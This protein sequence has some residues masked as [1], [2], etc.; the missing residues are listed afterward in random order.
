MK[1]MHKTAPFALV[2]LLILLSI[3]CSG[4]GGEALTATPEATATPEPT[5]TPSTPGVPAGWELVESKKGNIA[6][7]FPPGWTEFDLDPDT[8][9][10]ALD[11]VTSENPELADLLTGQ[12]STLLESGAVLFG[13]DLRSGAASKFSA[14]MNVLKL[15]LGAKMP[16]ADLTEATA[17]QLETTQTLTSAGVDVETAQTVSGE[18][19][20]LKYNIAMT[21]G[22]EEGNLQA[23][24]ML[25][26]DDTTLY[27]MTLMCTVDKYPDYRDDFDQM[28]SSFRVLP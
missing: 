17:A 18:A 8:L 6:V 10:Q 20:I 26:L 22:G 15:D 3:A 9:D 28:I 25:Y 11:Q 21:I 1:S 5:A 23:I 24:Q 4:I 27:L 12:A 7:A 14:N 16:I 19:G 13:I 2:A